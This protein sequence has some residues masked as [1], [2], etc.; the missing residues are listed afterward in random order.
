MLQR[1]VKIVPPCAHTNEYDMKPCIMKP[2]IVRLRVIP[3]HGR[4]GGGGP[5]G[6]DPLFG[7]L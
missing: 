4:I 2:Y 5:G 6:P 7:P 3:S 1:N